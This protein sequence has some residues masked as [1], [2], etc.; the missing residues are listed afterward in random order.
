MTENNKIN[1]AGISR[2]QQMFT[3]TFG[4]GPAASLSAIIFMGLVII[5]ALFWFFHSA[6]PKTIIFSSGDDGTSFQ[7]NAEKYA[8]ILARNGVQ[9]K[10]LKSEGSLENLERLN[11]PSFKVDVGF[12]Q[13]GVAKGQNIGNLVSLGS[14]SYEPLHIFY[15]SEKPLD[16]LSQFEGKRLAIGEQGTGTHVLA[17]ELLAINGIKPGGSTTLL[18]MDDEEA[19]A[20]LLAG[21]IDAVFMMSDSASSKTVH[22]LLVKPGIRLFDFSQADAY[23]RRITYLHKTVLPMGSIDFGKNIP[24]HDIS[25]VSPTVELIARADLHPALS[26]LLLEAATEV[27]SRAGL[28]HSRGEFPAAIENEYRISPDAARFYKSGKSFLY[29]YMPFWLASLLNRTLVAFVPMLLV[30]IPG[31]RTIPA[32]YRWQMRLRIFRRYRALMVLEKDM[33]ADGANR[34]EL[35]QRLDNI[36]KA[37]NKMKIP[38][39]FAEQFYGLRGNIENVRED[40]TNIGSEKTG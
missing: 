28:T 20:A 24:D 33:A 10:I 29:R 23:I 16:L 32:I 3:E 30:L 4:I 17:L 27:H 14:I 2:I 34:E 9:L 38:A 6:P 8:K 26:D 15:C 18:E 35:S 11:N 39:S 5:I 12:V 40:L 25:L 31:M 36:E 37:V 7:R 22:V 13:T 21:K 19:Q 1:Y